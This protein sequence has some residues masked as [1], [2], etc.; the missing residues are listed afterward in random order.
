MQPDTSDILKWRE[1]VTEAQ[2]GIK[3]SKKKTKTKINIV[4][5]RN[6]INE[7][8]V[9]KAL[10]IVLFYV[11]FGYGN[12]FANLKK[13]LLTTNKKVLYRHGMTTS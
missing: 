6:V 11:S 3:F 4:V 2:H 1:S 8:K 12:G 5:Q 13:F 9:Y 7:I 10:F